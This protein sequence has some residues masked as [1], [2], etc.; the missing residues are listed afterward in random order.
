MIV[1]LFTCMQSPIFPRDFRDSNALIELPPSLFVRASATW[2][3]CLNYRGGTSRPS[4]VTLR[5][6]FKL[7][8]LK[9]PTEKIWD[10]EQSI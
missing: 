10:C 3:E 4:Q 8:S 1:R 2:R 7:M 6:Q 5:Q 9:N